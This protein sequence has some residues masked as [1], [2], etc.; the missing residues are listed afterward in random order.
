LEV[1]LFFEDRPD[2]LHFILCVP[3]LEGQIEQLDEWTPESIPQRDSAGLLGCRVELEHGPEKQQTA[4]TP[5]HTGSISLT[6][7][8]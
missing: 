6:F 4:E 2:R 3:V 1:A 5:K 8:R 7:E